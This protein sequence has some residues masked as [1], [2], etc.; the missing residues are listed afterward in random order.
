[1]KIPAC[2]PALA[3]TVTSAAVSV[4]T[5]ATTPAA[6]TVA[7]STTPVGLLVPL[8]E[9]PTGTTATADWQAL[10]DAIDAHPQLP[11]YV[12]VN[13]GN[14]P[15]YSPNPPSSM[16][17]WAQWIDLIN[18]RSNA[19]TIGYIYTSAS[20]RDYA[21]L[22]S[23]VDQYAAWTTTAGFTNNASAYDIHIDGIFFDEI[24]TQPSKL[25]NNVAL[26]TYA[27]TAFAG[28]GGPVVLNPGTLVQAGSESLFDLA[29][30]ILQIETCYAKSSEATDP[31]NVLRCPAGG[32]TPFTT[33]TPATL[34]TNATR[35]AKSSIVVH[36]FYEQWSPFEAASAA[37]LQAG[38]DAVVNQGVHSF[39]FTTYGYTTNFT[40]APA[41]ITDVAAYAAQIQ[42]LS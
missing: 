19:K 3:S 23:A 33:A 24:D 32:Y 27:K 7:A 14:G 30:S 31:G 35:S 38:I 10:I 39:Y 40:S 16:P 34:G 15:P 21:T 41:S 18:A 25:S 6:P 13:D 2:L 36:D 9:Y 17:D 5:S 37:S 42:N 20:A 12:I 1:M 28:R 29:D 11:F 26:T 4:S 22:T 8:Y